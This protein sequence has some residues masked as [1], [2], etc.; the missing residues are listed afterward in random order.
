MSGAPARN[1]L[2]VFAALSG[3]AGVAMGAFGAHAL[4]SRLPEDLLAV[5]QTGVQYQL[6]HSIALLV[7]ALHSVRS[8]ALVWAGRSMVVGIVLF[9]GS[10]YALAL[11]GERWLGAVTPL[12]GVSLLCGWLLLA[13]HFI[14][15][16]S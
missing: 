8:A 6:W 10:L 14:R 4:R 7:L 5:Y 1:P 12:G 3:F 15:R 2:A 16:S 11:S 9:S 13:L